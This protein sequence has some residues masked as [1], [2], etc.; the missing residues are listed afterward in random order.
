MVVQITNPT[1]SQR[2]RMKEQEV[3]RTGW[4]KENTNLTNKAQH[5]SRRVVMYWNRVAKSVVE[6]YLGQGPGQPALL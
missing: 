6:S 5:F 1:A 3:T 4:R 2:C